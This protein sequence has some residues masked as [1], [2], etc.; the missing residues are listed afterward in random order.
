MIRRLAPI[1]VLALA[2]AAVLLV[3]SC[4]DAL[5]PPVQTGSYSLTTLDGNPPPFVL[6]DDHFSAGDRIVVEQVADS[7]AIQ[8]S[9]RLVRG[10]GIRV[11]FYAPDGSFDTLSSGWSRTASYKATTSGLATH[12]I[13]T[14]DALGDPMPSE[15]LEVAADRA[16]IGRRIIAGWCKT[17][18][19][20]ECPTTPRLREFVYD[21]R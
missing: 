13:V 17:G 6:S 2:F 10:Q 15:T 1:Q 4:S 14:F 8:S 11:W 9:S 12:L 20:E 7:I 5:G 3:W 21:L 19:P 18:P 16:I